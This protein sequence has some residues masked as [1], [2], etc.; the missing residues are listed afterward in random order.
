M[1]KLNFKEMEMTC[2]ELLTLHLPNHGSGAIY[3]HVY[4]YRQTKKTSLK[5][6]Y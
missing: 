3:V 4:T 2:T 1:N 5:G 6:I